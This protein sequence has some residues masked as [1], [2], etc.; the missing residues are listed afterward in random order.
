MDCPV[1]VTKM[2]MCMMK[3]HPTRL[4]SRSSEGFKETA[5]L[6]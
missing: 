6:E 3:M 2:S 5:K 4:G 1:L